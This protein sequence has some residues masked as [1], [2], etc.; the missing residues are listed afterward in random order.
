MKR[1]ILVVGMTG[2][3]YGCGTADKRHAEGTNPIEAISDN[4][5]DRVTPDWKIYHG[6]FPCVDCE[7]IHVELRME[8]ADTEA[9]PD[10]QM[11]MHYKDTPVG[12]T[13]E[14]LEG[15]YTV[16]PGYGKDL[17]ATLFQLNPGTGQPR[18]FLENNDQS[19]TMLGD[20]LQLLD[21]EG[22]LNYRLHVNENG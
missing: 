20:D 21:E 10:Y 2:I 8:K 5:V 16:I 11:V 4:L 18:Y 3:L 7:A 6:T 15:N 9:T 13:S 17:N 22:D 19:I 12:N 1:L 14:T